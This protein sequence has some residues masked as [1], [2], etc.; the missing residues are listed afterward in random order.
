MLSYISHPM[1]ILEK[2]L[3]LHCLILQIFIA[4]QLKACINLTQYKV[5]PTTKLLL[6]VKGNKMMLALQKSLI[7]SKNKQ[8]CYD[9]MANN[10]LHCHILVGFLNFLLCSLVYF[11]VKSKSRRMSFKL[12]YQN[13]WLSMYDPVQIWTSSSLSAMLKVLSNHL[14]IALERIQLF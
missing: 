9:Y 8:W 7:L 3:F 13:P 6:F 4:S 12:A 10:S 1:L 11:L 2:I 14:N 5:A